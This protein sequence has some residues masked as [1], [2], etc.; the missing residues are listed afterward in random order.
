MDLKAL[1]NLKLRNQIDDG[2][3]DEEHARIS[4]QLEELRLNE[5]MLRKD[6][7]QKVHVKERINEIIKVLT[8]RQELL[9]Q[10][11]DSLFHALVEKITILS[12][13][14]FIFTLKSGMELGLNDNLTSVAYRATLFR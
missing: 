8:T 14:H 4:Q 9:E 2:V 1:V 3:Y 7:E 13:A 5:T 11:D 6:H 12:P 10:F